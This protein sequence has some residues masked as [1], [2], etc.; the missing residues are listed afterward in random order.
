LPWSDPTPIPPDNSQ[1][2]SQIRTHYTTSFKLKRLQ[3]RL[4]LGRYK[5]LSSIRFR[6]LYQSFT[7]NYL[8]NGLVFQLEASAVK[9]FTHTMLVVDT[10]EVL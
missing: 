3:D 2:F 4:I 1:E 8:R 6:N 7:T 5:Q 10:G 9:E